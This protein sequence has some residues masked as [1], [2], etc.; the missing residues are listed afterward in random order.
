MIRARAIVQELTSALRDR[1]VFD[2][3]ISVRATAAGPVEVRG[4]GAALEYGSVVVCAGRG[5]APLARGA[6][7]VLPVRQAVH[8]RLGYRVRGEPPDRLACL[9][10]S[11]GAF[12][13]TTNAYGDALPGNDVY[14]VG[15]GDIS[16]HEDGSPLDAAGLSK[17]AE[18]TTDYVRRALPGLDPRP[19][20]VR[21]CWVTELPW[22][23]DGIAVWQAGGLIAVAGNNLFKHA[24]ALG[25]AL[26]RV[27]LG[28]GLAPHLR[29][30]AKLGAERFGST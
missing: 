7:L 27:A 5:T 10:D 30:E 4:G 13:E 20:D 26:A 22:S 17:A 23:A 18:R 2:E 3:V 25:R 6:G 11:S 21:H 9:L 15:L 12:G 28:K 1:L 14:A 19:V 8:V 16:V 24:P 29:P